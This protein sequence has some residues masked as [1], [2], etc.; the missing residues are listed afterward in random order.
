MVWNLA[1]FADKKLISRSLAVIGNTTCPAS[2]L[3]MAQWHLD[4]LDFILNEYS[5]SIFPFPMCPPLIF[6]EIINI[7][8]LR[9]RAFRS[10][11]DDDEGL[12][13]EAYGILSRIDDFST[14]QWAWSKPCAH[15][16]WL[17]VGNIYK[18][19]TTIYC[20]SSLQSLS[21]LPLTGPLRFRCAA[22]GKSLHA[23]LAKA[24]STP[25]IGGFLL[26]PLVM[27][28]MEAANGCSVSRAFVA[29][30]LPEMSRHVG[31][32]APLTAKAVLERFWASEGTG[33]DLCFDRPY[34]FATQIAVDLS[35][36]S[37]P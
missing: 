21:I 26:W 30:Q 7:N 35:R 31:S 24:L 2:E 14:E 10:G 23:F 6:V 1:A 5:G 37:P 11:L 27:L 19:A 36:L 20:I 28:G 25:G 3:A 34:V 17:L 22:L 4:E 33:W 13:D 8:H 32:Y 29:Q 15:E 18:A 16:E 9:M 12:S